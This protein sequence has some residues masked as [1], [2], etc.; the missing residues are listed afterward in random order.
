MGQAR[1]L[2][3]TSHS[4]KLSK[5]MWPPL[6]GLGSCGWLLAGTNALSMVGFMASYRSMGRMPGQ[7][8][9]YAQTSQAR[10]SLAHSRGAIPTLV[11]EPQSPK[12]SKAPQ[13]KFMS[14]R[15]HGPVWPSIS[16]PQ[17]K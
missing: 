16:R 5:A 14:Q 6:A 7:G 10:S 9:A 1:S 15:P 11:T 3:K 4:R 8:L 12:L 13:S 17:V 2:Q